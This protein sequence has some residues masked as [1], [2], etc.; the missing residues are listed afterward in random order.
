M[1][2]NPDR[3]AHASSR[4]EWRL[5]LCPFSSGRL[6]SLSDGRVKR[7][8]GRADR[9][10]PSL[11]PSKLSDN[12]GRFIDLLLLLLHWPIW[13]SKPDN[14]SQSE[15]VV[16]KICHRSSRGDPPSTLVAVASSSSPSSTVTWR[17]HESLSR[18]L[19]ELHTSELRSCCIP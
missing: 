13:M 17:Y 15:L 5:S 19:L 6:A 2:H 9:I 3:L 16:F 4:T 11:N 18:Q 14:L 1:N 12:L 8:K 7:R 10:R